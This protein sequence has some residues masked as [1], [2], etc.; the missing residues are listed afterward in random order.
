MYNAVEPAAWEPPRQVLDYGERS[1][2]LTC[3]RK[4]DIRI[5]KKSTGAVPG[6]PASTWASET[7]SV[8]LM[9]S[10]LSDS[11]WCP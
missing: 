2:A 9:Y 5:G 3:W 4:Y 8:I 11:I 7:F 6:S 1:A 10:S